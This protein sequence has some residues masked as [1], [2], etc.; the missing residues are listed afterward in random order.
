[1]LSKLGV[2]SIV[3]LFV[4]A[5]NLSATLNWDVPLIGIEDAQA[6]GTCLSVYVLCCGGGQPCSGWEDCTEPYEAGHTG[7]PCATNSNSC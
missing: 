4:G 7:C 2:L 1:M 3:V 6:S 5:L